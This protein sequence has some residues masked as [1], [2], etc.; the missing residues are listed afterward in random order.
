MSK[1]KKILKIFGLILVNVI[2]LLSAAFLS[3]MID[4]I[5]YKMTIP[6]WGYFLLYMPTYFALPLFI[7]FYL[8]KTCGGEIY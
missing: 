5:Y 2:L 4:T 1:L 3:D 6:K 8:H 7:Y